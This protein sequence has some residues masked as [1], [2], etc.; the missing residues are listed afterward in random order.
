MPT[1]HE[2][3]DAHT[4][5]EREAPMSRAY[6]YLAQMHNALGVTE[7]VPT[8]VE[9]FFDRPYLVPGKC[10]PGT[11]IQGKITD[12]EVKRLPAY[13]GSVDQLTNVVCVRDWPNR[14][15]GLAGLYRGGE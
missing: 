6:V 14:R 8:E 9:P 5:R 3:L 13:V 7:P 10:N 11:A 15:A 2:A 12:E 1:F 4:W